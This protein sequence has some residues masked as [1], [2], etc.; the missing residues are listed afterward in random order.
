MRAGVAVGGKH[1]P[2]GTTLD[3]YPLQTLAEIRQPIH[4]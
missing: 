1:A 3:L 2:P 4:R